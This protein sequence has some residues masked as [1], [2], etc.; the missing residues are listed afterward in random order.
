ML[1]TH[2]FNFQQLDIEIG[3]IENYYFQFI[4]DSCCYLIKH[5]LRTIVGVFRSS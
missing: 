2:F 1:I 5:S 3:V 4:Y